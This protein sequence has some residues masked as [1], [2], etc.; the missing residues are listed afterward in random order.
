MIDGFYR[1]AF[2]GSH[3]GGFGLLVLSNGKLAGA[4]IA[5]AVYDGAY[6]FSPPGDSLHLRITLRAPAGITL[7]QTG[8]P[9]SAPT[10]MPIEAHLPN[11]LANGSPLL[12]ETP[13]GKVNVA[14]LKIRDI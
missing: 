11:D 7:V 5:G 9:L 13:L 1:V 8:V 12:I 2:T 14:F 3:G 4:D 6:E 10:D